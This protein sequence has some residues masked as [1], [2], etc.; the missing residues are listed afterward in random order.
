MPY[1][2][3]VIVPIVSALLAGGGLSQGLPVFE[4]HGSELTEAP[5]VSDEGAPPVRP[6]PAGKWC[7][8]PF[9]F[10]RNEGQTDPSVAFVARAAGATI[11]LQW[12]GAIFS[13]G[14]SR[15]IAM[16]FEGASTETQ[17]L[18]ADRLPG[19]TRYYLGNDPSRWVPEAPH[20]ARVH[21]KGLY[22]GVDVV[23][24]GNPRKLEYDLLLEAGVDPAVVQL[25]FEGMDSLAIEADGSLA[26]RAGSER[27]ALK[28][29]RVWQDREDGRRVLPSRWLVRGSARVA[30]AIDG[31]DPALPL[32]IDPEVDLAFSTF[33]GGSNN[34]MG[35]DIALGVEGDPWV[36]GETLSLDFPGTEE[37]LT[38]TG[39]GG[40]GFDAFLAHLDSVGQTLISTTI[41]GGASDEF[42]HGVAHHPG[43]DFTVFVGVTADPLS[44]PVFEPSPRARGTGDGDGKLGSD[45]FIVA[46]NSTG[47]IF[48]AF[49]FGGSSDDVANDV[50]FDFDISKP[51][52]D[53]TP[54]PLLLGV[55][56]VGQTMSTDY[57]A[58]G[59]Q[60]SLQG[61][62]D[63]FVTRF[64]GGDLFFHLSTYFGGSSAEGANG[65]AVDFDG[66]ILFGGFTTS[67]DLPLSTVVQGSLNGSVDGFMSAVDVG[68]NSLQFSTYLGG[69]DGDEVLDVAIRGADVI[70]VG[71]TASGDF[72]TT[73]G[74]LQRTVP[75]P[76]GKS[77]NGFVS[78]IGFEPEFTLGIGDDIAS[79]LSSTYLGGDDLD[80]VE[81]VAITKGGDVVTLLTTTSTDLPVE[82]GAGWP[83]GISPFDAYVARFS[84]DLSTLVYSTYLGGQFNDFGGGVAVGFVDSLDDVF[85][86][87]WT[88]SDDFPL[89][90]PFQDQINTPPVLPVATGDSSFSPDAFV[91]KL[92]FDPKG[93]GQ[94]DLTVA[95]GPNTPSAGAVGC[96]GEANVLLQF[97]VTSEDTSTENATLNSFDLTAFGTGDESAVVEQVRIVRDLDGDG[98]ID[99]GEPT[100]GTATFN[101]DDGSVNLVLSTPQTLAPD[102]TRTYL[103]V[104]DLGMTLLASTAAPSGNAKPSADADGSSA[105]ASPVSHGWVLLLPLAIPL[106]RR[107]K[108]DGGRRV[109]TMLLVALL[110]IGCL[111]MSGCRRGNHFL[112]NRSFGVDATA[113]AAVPEN[114]S[115]TITV[116]G[117]PLA[118]IAL[119]VNQIGD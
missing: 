32:V 88:E 66:S 113:L 18:G 6:S 103:V 95:L 40:G 118:G 33:L 100:I 93:E 3:S 108:G 30:F 20:F 114:V 107:R 83:D 26:L 82:F 112:F 38:G 63:A 27:L 43:G 15:S 35:E 67:D 21:A 62:S 13:L 44:F 75:G 60:N 90:N 74:S 99:G 14:D 81:G 25:R 59:F 115:T 109:P 69:S 111:S 92:V 57:P 12:D 56:V 72:P 110:A 119:K 94:I 23:Y 87:G 10:E 76:I 80:F 4:P 70:G 9:V 17:V 49:P 8:L 1:S 96:L 68:G 2:T 105:P 52:G 11:F 98:A 48:R 64:A 36:T 37:L 55:V 71:Y 77:S 34:D 24:Y 85:V 45:A 47:E 16:R 116:V 41:I 78:I 104:Y 50:A 7:A 39:D 58:K 86:T 54:P 31:I 5:R 91:T 97:T 106:L 89:A 53:G 22:Q 79:L 61:P 29:P 102:E 117:F 19:V 84:G 101:A 42:A 65:V 51:T 28:A 73:P 46:V